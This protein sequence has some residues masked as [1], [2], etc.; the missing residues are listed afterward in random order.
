MTDRLNKALNIGIFLILI[1]SM[2]ASSLIVVANNANSKQTRNYTRDVVGPKQLLNNTGFDTYGSSWDFQHASSG[3]EEFITVDYD[4]IVTPTHVKMFSNA[5]VDTYNPITLTAFVNQTFYKPIWT[6]NYISA[7]YCKFNWDMVV[8]TADVSGAPFNCEIFLRIINDTLPNNI[9]EWSIASGASAVTPTDG[10]LGVRQYVNTKVGSHPGL[11]TFVKPGYYTLAIMYRVNIP[12]G[13]S[14]IFE[15]DLRIDNVTLW[16]ADS[17]EPSITCSK[18]SFGPYNADP[19]DP[20]DLIDVDFEYGGNENTSLKL[21]KY[22]L[23]NGGTPGAWNNIF[24]WDGQLPVINSYTQNWSI[25]SIWKSLAE[26]QNTI[27]VY[28]EDEVGNFNDSLQINIFKDTVAPQSNTSSLQEYTT[29]KEFDISYIAFDQTPTGGFNN[30]VQLWFDYKG[31]GYV[32]Y[33]P[34]WAPDGNLT[35]SPIKFNIS[36]T[37]A[38]GS[39]DEGKYKFYTIAIDNATNIESPPAPSSPDAITTIDYKLPVSKVT[40]PTEELLS[41]TEFDVVF[42]AADT[43][44]GIDYV[45]LWYLLNED[46]YRWSGTGSEDGKF[47]S[48]PIAFT[49]SSDGLYG[50]L[51][52]A[53]DQ[54]GLIELNG[55]PDN[56]PPL[57]P[58]IE[59]K[60]DTQA[61]SPEFLLPVNDHV[62]EKVTLTVISDFDT[63]TIAFYYWIDVDGDGAADPASAGGDDIG[64]SWKFIY[65]ITEQPEEGINWTTEWNTKDATRFDE[66]VDEEHMVILKATGTDETFKH[67][68]GFKNLIEVDNIPPKVEITNPEANTAENDDLMTLSYTLDNNDGEA[69][70]FYWSYFEENNWNIINEDNPYAHPS[71]ELKGSY[72]WK[73]PAKLKSEQATIDIKMEVYDDTENAGES[74][75]G[76]IYINRQGPEPKDGFPVEITLDEDFPEYKLTLTLFEAHS[77]PSY[78]GDNLKWYVTGNSKKVF[79]ITGDNSTG[80]NADTFTYTSRPNMYGTETLIFHLVDPLGLEATIEQTVVV[81]AVNDPPILNLPDKTFHVTY[82]IQDTIDFSLY[83]SDVDN[84]VSELTLAASSDDYGQYLTSSGLSVTFNLPESLNDKILTIKLTLTDGEDNEDETIRVKV[85]GNHR[86][87]WTKAFPTGV[88]LTENVDLTNYLD[89][90]DYFTD[91]DGDTLYYS[92]PVKYTSPNVIVDINPENQ[93]SFKAKPNVAGKVTVWFRAEDSN[94]AWTDGYMVLELIDIPDPPRIKHIPDMNIHWWN[95]GDPGY[96]YDFS[97]FI[98]DPDNADSE[99]TIWISTG[100]DEKDKWIENDPNNN[101]KII[102]KFPFSAAGNTYP[103]A[104]Y[105]VDPQAKQAYRVFNITVIFENWPVEQIKSIP[106]QYFD[107]D[108]EKDNAFDLQEYFRDLDGGTSYEISKD[109]H[110]NLDAD[111]DENNYVDLKSKVKDWNTGTSYVELVIVAKDTNFIEGYPEHFVYATVRVFVVPQNDAPVLKELLPINVT[112]NE[113]K[114]YDINTLITDVDTDISSLDIETDTQEHID[115]KV[116]GTVLIIKSDKAGKYTVQ[117]W[118]RDVDGSKSNTRE[119]SVSVVKQKV[120]DNETDQLLIYGIIGLV[121]VIV[122]ILVVLVVI[123]TQYKVEEVFLIHKSGILLS[124]L[125]RE[126]KPGR[127]EEILSGMFTAVQEFIKDSFSTGGGTGD[128]HILREMKIGAHK[129]ILIERG[130]YIY[131]AVIFSGRGAGKLRTKL[132]NIL[133]NVETKY[134]HAFR[135]WV[136]DMDKIAGVE[137]LLR[138]LLPAGGTPVMTTDK[139]LGRVPAPPST[140]VAPIT[141]SPAAPASAPAVPSHAPTRITPAPVAAAPARPAAVKPI[142]PIKPVTPVKP[143]A[144]VQPAAVRPAAVRPAAIAAKPAATALPKQAGAAPTNC[145]KCGAV[146]NKFPDGSM[147]CPKCG[148]TG[149]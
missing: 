108:E 2:A 103:V 101:M 37:G 51:T 8:Y 1:C 31:G 100:D 93:A 127:D 125:S 144:A 35:K 126:R 128:D 53:Y 64:S 76:P 114:T 109:T 21:A 25:S 145:P 26:G 102:F 32:Q 23:N 105:A 65:N 20:D 120:T 10:R 87:K 142:S 58:D 57:T 43:G 111:I 107:E 94:G 86:P 50:F 72:D 19:V 136:G 113:E 91:Q 9:G 7:L 130:K 97:Y 77:N 38:V 11:F 122:L 63:K 140:P 147:L 131:L 47:D 106:D 90:D 29:T 40:A 67:G 141:P 68:D 149:N 70:Y 112:V 143:I 45:E 133:E 85:T 60:V 92:T 81:N 146:P 46:W 79:Y 34:S 62:K 56:T 116:S 42:T 15:L 5:P 36:D 84:D 61:P 88:V 49:A 55:T 3:A 27:D 129:N 134:E 18:T 110:P 48:S 137:N 66:F 30:T 104:L 80:N 73:I 12:T 22:R 83:V 39:F 6:P 75:V 41:T 69:T 98:N 96:G 118:I 14:P 138:P 135:S 52:V 119:L 115:I 117:V 4:D 89:L 124:H 71:G 17:H 78:T 82:G 13:S 99:L 54:S 44:S 121:I 24:Y 16:I 139:Q 74:I 33:K 148:Y 132:R 28:C 59:V 123:F 95:P